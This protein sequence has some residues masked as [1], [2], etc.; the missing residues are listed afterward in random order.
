MLSGAATATDASAYLVMDCGPER[1]DAGDG[2][3]RG[4]GGGAAD[5]SALTNLEDCYGSASVGYRRHEGGG[6]AERRKKAHHGL[7][8]MCRVVDQDAEMQ[9]AERGKVS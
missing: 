8:G 9:R 1:G 2:G 4:G 7:D 3:M 6:C 5:D